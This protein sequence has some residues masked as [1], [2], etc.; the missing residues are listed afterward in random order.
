[1]QRQWMV[2]LT[3]PCLMAAACSSQPT[4]LASTQESVVL[5][6]DLND[7]DWPKDLITLDSAVVTPEG[8]LRLFTKYGGG[9]AD[10]TAA[11]LVGRAFAESSPPILRARIA[12]D[13]KNDACRALVAWTLEFELKPVRDHFQQTYGSGTGSVVLDVGGQRVTYDFQ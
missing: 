7:S 4:G 11:L 8:R 9:C 1:M 13:A 10:H 6:N 5:V 2:I 12:H 3:A